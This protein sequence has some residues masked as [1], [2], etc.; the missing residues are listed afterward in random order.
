[1]IFVGSIL[2]ATFCP[3][4]S[5]ETSAKM[6]G[7]VTSSIGG[8]L[9]DEDRG[10]SNNSSPSL[11]SLV[12]LTL[13]IRAASLPALTELCI[14]AFGNYIQLQAKLRLVMDS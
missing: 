14:M 6:S 11:P 5:T 7:V 9:L 1:M 12:G 8:I 4:I 3:F 2:H 13:R 10:S